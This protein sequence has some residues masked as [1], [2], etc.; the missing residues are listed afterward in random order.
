MNEALPSKN[1]PKLAVGQLN[2]KKLMKYLFRQG[3][4]VMRFAGTKDCKQ[5]HISITQIVW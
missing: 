5:I 2:T 3:K 4:T 1:G